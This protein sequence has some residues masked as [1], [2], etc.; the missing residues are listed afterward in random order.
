MLLQSSIAPHLARDPLSQ[1]GVDFFQVLVPALGDGVAL[2]PVHA[3]ARLRDGGGEFLFELREGCVVPSEAGGVDG[4]LAAVLVFAL[5]DGAFLG[6]DGGAV[7]VWSWFSRRRCWVATVAR[8]A[9]S[10]RRQQAAGVYSFASEESSSSRRAKRKAR[11]V[12]DM[13]GCSLG[14]ERVA[15]GWVVMV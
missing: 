8:E 15:L 9:S 11:A 4:A 7:L 1:V 2:F 10:A 3:A 12:V 6:G 14:W 5:F 13:V